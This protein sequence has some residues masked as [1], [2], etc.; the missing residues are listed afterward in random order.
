MHADTLMYLIT[1]NNDNIIKQFDDNVNI[2][3]MI[4]S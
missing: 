4:F 3:E 2:F 1:Y